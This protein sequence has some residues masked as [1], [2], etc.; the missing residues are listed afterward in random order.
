MEHFDLIVIGGGP[1]GYAG[2][3]RAV[4]FGKKVLLVEKKRIGGAGVY[5]GVLTSKTLWEQALKVAS[6]R[7]MIPNYEVKFEDISKI[8]NE[9]VFE[10]KTQMT[11]HLQLLQKMPKQLFFYEKGRAMIMDKHIIEITKEDGSVKRVS[12][13]NILIAT[14]SRPRIPANIKVDEKIIVTS[15][16]IKNFTDWPESM[17]VLGAGVIGCEFAT[18]FS[19]FGKTKVFLIDKAE[20]IL[21]FEDADVAEVVE[22]SLELQGAR[23][24][25]GA[26]LKRMEIKNGKVE[27][28]LE[29]KNGQTEIMVVDKALI[30]IGR[31]ANVEG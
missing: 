5:D 25:H 23:V 6:I 30:S 20:R 27:Y 29:Y 17:V 24:H 22:N 18:I 31:C 21:P 13:D 10:R 8:V 4:D 3:M 14:G 11:V 1:S 2:A 12:C 9:A 28:E 16:G 7:E 26:S 19:A 15:D